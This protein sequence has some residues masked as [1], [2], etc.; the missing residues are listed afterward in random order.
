MPHYYSS[1][2]MH[3][4]NL[5]ALNKRKLKQNWN[6]NLSLRQ[7]R[8]NY[9]LFDSIELDRKIYVESFFIQDSNHCFQSL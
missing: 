9:D 3:L 4:M 7:M 8:T 6:L 2:T 5:R 1:H